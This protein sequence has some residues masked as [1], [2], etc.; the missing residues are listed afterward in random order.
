MNRVYFID[1]ARG[2][3]RLDAAQ[4]PL[5][6]GGEEVADIVL[7]GSP[8]DRIVAYVALS[9]GHAYLQPVSAEDALFHNHRHLHESAWLKS[10]D[11]VQAG[12]AV[13]HWTVQ[14]DQVHIVVRAHQ[15]EPEQQPPALRPPPG[16]P[17]LPGTGAAPAM[18]LGVNRLSGRSGHGKAGIWVS[19]PLGLASG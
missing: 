2:A 19:C 16:K 1:D 9:D 15:P 3:R 5:S 11:Q 18:P 10:G 8:A 12:D 6:L 14:G 4:L 7:P 13:L 17:L